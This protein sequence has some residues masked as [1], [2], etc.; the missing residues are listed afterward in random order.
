VSLGDDAGVVNGRKCALERKLDLTG[1]R[2]KEIATH[3]MA[4]RGCWNAVPNRAALQ[5]S[6][7]ENCADGA[8]GWIQASCTTDSIRDR[9]SASLSLAR[10]TN[11][12]AISVS[13][14]D[15]F[16]QCIKS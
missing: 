10:P 7:V 6:L 14:Y 13:F 9:K 1:Q 4:F 11:F 12:C 15:S 3:I 16:H 8:S 2:S 5:P